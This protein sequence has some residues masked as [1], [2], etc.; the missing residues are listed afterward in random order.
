MR[1]MR[2]EKVVCDRT[3]WFAS[4]EAREAD[5][6]A[7][8]RVGSGERAA[9]GRRPPAHGVPTAAKAAWARSPAAREARGSLIG[10]HLPHLGAGIKNAGIFRKYTSS[11]PDKLCQSLRKIPA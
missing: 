6:A 10:S 3:K 8:R 7:S 4:G 5:A 2:T 9:G 1:S 11:Y